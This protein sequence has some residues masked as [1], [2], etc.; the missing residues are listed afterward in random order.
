MLYEVITDND[1]IPFMMEQ[2]PEFA[3]N[4]PML[5]MAFAVLLALTF[6]NEMMRPFHVGP[7]PPNSPAK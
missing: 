1:S 7:I 2:I 3:A 4:H 6:F 5:V